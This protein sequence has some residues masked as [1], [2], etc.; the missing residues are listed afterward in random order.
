[1]IKYFLEDNKR[2]FI[3]IA[4]GIA[5]LLAGLAF[6]S[7]YYGSYKKQANSYKEQVAALQDKRDLLNEEITKT[8]EKV[9]KDNMAITEEKMKKDNDIVRKHFKSFYEW[10]SKA[11]Y[12]KAMKTGAEK[13]GDQKDA[14]SEKFKVNAD[15][16]EKKKQKS[17]INSVTLYPRKVEGG[18]TLYYARLLIERTEL[19]GDASQIET[20]LSFSINAD[21]DVARVKMM[22]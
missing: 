14:F 9:A 12:E 18:T 4:I 6:K 15:E 21:G 10:D 17:A 3:M 1:M 7:V 2:C 19:E 8:T 20:L 16:I 11:S 22:Y 13:F 5:V